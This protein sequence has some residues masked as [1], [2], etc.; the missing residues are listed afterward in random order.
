MNFDNIFRLTPG[1]M[2]SMTPEQRTAAEAYIAQ[3]NYFLANSAIF[4]ERVEAGLTHWLRTG[5]MP[6]PFDEQEPL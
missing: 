2:A 4:R 3:T 5:E 1:A 6:E